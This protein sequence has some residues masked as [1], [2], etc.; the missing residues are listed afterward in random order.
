MY[1]SHMSTLPTITF[2]IL[3]E[4]IY[5]LDIYFRYRVKYDFYTLTYTI[6]FSLGLLKGHIYMHVFQL[7]NQRIMTN[8]D[9][10][11]LFKLH[12]HPVI[13]T[14]SSALFK[15]STHPVIGLVPLPKNHTFDSTMV[16]SSGSIMPSPR[17]NGWSNTHVTSCEASR[18]TV[19]IMHHYCS[20]STPSRGRGRTF[21]STST[22][23]ISMGSKMLCGWP[24]GAC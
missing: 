15:L 19:L 5:I 18:I 2:L 22:G 17:W 24:G 10:S 4:V 16:L 3:T 11:D 9:S 23:P 20:C 12:T 1:V 8:A 7:S 13:N 14:D 21:A 6:F